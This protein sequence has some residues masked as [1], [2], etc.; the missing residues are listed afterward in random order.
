MQEV[1]SQYH[2]IIQ[3]LK[4]NVCNLLDSGT[5]DLTIK[6][7]NV[8]Q[9]PVALEQIREFPLLFFVVGTSR[10][11]DAVSAPV[12][13][14]GATID[15]LVNI[16]IESNDD[17]KKD[18][19]ELSADARESMRVIVASSKRV[20]NVKTSTGLNT[21]KDARINRVIPF[22]PRRDRRSDKDAKRELLLFVVE[23]DYIYRK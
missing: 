23:I 2:R 13:Y 1:K 20:G 18:L 6:K 9:R 15:I 4:N 12:G 19:L 7:E 14:A 22:R 5:L 17:N 21:T 8:R 10:L 3:G 11:N 16:G